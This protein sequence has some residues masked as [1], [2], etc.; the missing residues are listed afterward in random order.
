[1]TDRRGNAAKRL[2][3]L[4]A[5]PW[6]SWPETDRVARCIRFVVTYCRPGKGHGAGELLQLAPFQE[7]FI[8]DVY[9]EG[10]RAAGLSIARANGKSTLLGAV[11][12]H[13]LF[14]AP[15]E[16]GSPQIPVIATRLHQIERATYDVCI[17]M[18]VAEPELEGRA[19]IFSG[20]GNRKI[21]CPHNGG[22]MFPVSKDLAGLQ[23]L[24]PSLAVVDELEFM[25]IESW[26][27]VILASG[28]RPSSVVVGIGTPGIDRDN[29]MFMLR[30]LSS[31]GAC[32]PGFAFTEIAADEGCA[33]DDEDQWRRANPALDAGFASIDAPRTTLAMS[34]VEDFKRF[35]LGLWV[36][37][38]GSWL[39]EDALVL[40]RSLL[41]PHEMTDAAA[42]WV[43]VDVG[44]KRDTSAV[45][46]AQRRPDGRVHVAVR[47]WRPSG[48][49]SLETSQIMAFLRELAITYDLQAVAYDP[50]SFEVV[51]P[52]LLDE[53]LPMVE[54]PQ[55]VETMTPI[56][57]GVYEAIRRKELT[58]DDDRLF[59]RHVLN[60]Q[61]RANE[62]GFTLEQGP[63]E[64]QDRRGDRRVITRSCGSPV[65]LRAR[66]TFLLDQQEPSARQCRRGRNADV[67]RSS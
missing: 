45:A 44:L 61:T 66:R 54:T 52:Q 6:E 2:P 39:G 26:N 15:V 18:I 29:A 53:G 40:W 65:C 14:D 36:E 21:V 19:L 24:D 46:W 64:G 20:L 67:E 63:L 41:E 10:V 16:G 3:S 4:P 51:G 28:K 32:P 48:D 50:R 27:A 34:T 23:G 1:M 55:S 31:S 47:I 58:H 57:G 5:P 35:R 12:L 30:E 33:L 38:V 8:G 25:P 49:G 13:A 59:E 42:T 9:S 43:G 37:G 22:E 7:A 62:R 17:A 11:A 56:V 60:A